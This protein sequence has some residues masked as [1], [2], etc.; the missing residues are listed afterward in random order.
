MKKYDYLIVGAG[1]YGAIVAYRARKAG[2]RVLVIEKREHIGGNLYCE[3]MTYPKGEDGDVIHV[4]RYGPHI[5]HTSNKEVWDFV[6]SLV[7]F[8][9]FR[10]CPLASFEDRLYHLP[11][12]MNTFYELWGTKTPE[13][14]RKRLAQ[15][16]SCVDGNVP[17]NLEEQA[18]SLVGKEI[19]QK[20]IKGY[21]EKQWG[22]NC[23][24]LPAFI[25]RRL[26]VRYYYD[27]NYF[28]DCY[29]GIPIGGYNK[30]FDVLLEEVDVKT[31]I[32]FF[33]NSEYYLSMA[34]KTVYCGPI[35]QF[36]DYCY[37]PLQYRSLRFETEVLPIESYQGNAAVNYT[38]HD[39]TFTR[40]IEHKYFEFGTQNW[41][42]ITKEYS[43]EWELGME[44]YYP[45]NDEFN[46]QLLKKYQA[47]A[48]KQSNVFFCGRL[49][50][51]KY[52][53][54]HQIVEKALHFDI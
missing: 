19:Y 40:I 41:T 12:N 48:E 20:L 27:N 51:Y 6:N 53:D 2:K 54:M 36:F 39:K 4:H 23:K 25:I 10:Y 34:E 31:G 43:Q 29:Q 42:V 33:T 26:P 5:F 50:E 16:R 21:T 30:L 44:P 17:Q 13:E 11:F 38:G 22:R 46:Q 15:E 7:P 52:Y 45:V 8:N 1:L 35:D 32:D 9:H 3:P 28:N 14:A 18:I 37:G 49:A 24:D 47:L